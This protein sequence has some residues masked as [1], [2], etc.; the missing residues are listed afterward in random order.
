MA[1]GGDSRTQTVYAAVSEAARAVLEREAQLRDRSL[2]MLVFMILR[3]ATNNFTDFSV[4][5]RGLPR[6]QVGLRER[7]R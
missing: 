4:I 7:E 5:D 1:K 2:G 3:N 6:A